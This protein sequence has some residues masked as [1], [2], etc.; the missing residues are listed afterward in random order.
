MGASLPDWGANWTYAIKDRDG[1]IYIVG[2]ND[3]G[4]SIGIRRFLA[5]L[6]HKIL[7][8]PAE[9][10]HFPTLG[11]SVKTP[12]DEG[13]IQ[14]LAFV[15]GLALAFDNGT[16]SMTTR[17]QN[18]LDRNGCI[19]NKLWSSGHAYAAMIAAN[20]AAFDAHDEYTGGGHGA[21]GN[22]ICTFEPG[23][24]AIA[25]SYAQGQAGPTR[26]GVSLTAADGDVGWSFDARTDE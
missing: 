9:W 5:G 21:Q 10:E 4:V 26:N 14:C 7:W 23:V 2:L 12:P 15:N 17:R 22:K 20:Q 24:Q 16:A 1:S 18:F 13:P 19:N 6:G 3:Q 8:S 25:L 11:S